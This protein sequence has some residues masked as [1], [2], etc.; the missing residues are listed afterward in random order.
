MFPFFP[1]PVFSVTMVDS[2][3]GRPLKDPDNLATATKQGVA[4]SEIK[5]DKNGRL[6]LI[7]HKRKLG[8]WDGSRLG[9]GK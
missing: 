3:T 4:W 9:N 2:Q 1:R 7:N 5:R 6:T 8:E